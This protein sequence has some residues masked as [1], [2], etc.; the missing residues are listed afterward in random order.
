MNVYPPQSGTLQP[1]SN[2]GISGCPA[3][4]SC[5]GWIYYPNGTS[6]FFTTDPSKTKCVVQLF[7][8]AACT[9][10][11]LVGNYGVLWRSGASSYGCMSAAGNTKTFPATVNTHYGF[12]AYILSGSAAKYYMTVNFQ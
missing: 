4:T 1:S 12:T 7:T 11:V 2:T 3:N 10:P 8:D 5:I 9:I 6:G